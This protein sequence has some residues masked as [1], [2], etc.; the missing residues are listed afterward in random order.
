VENA[1]LFASARAKERLDHEIK[2]ASE[3]QQKLLPKSLPNSPDI[4]VSGFTLACYSVGGDCFDVIELGDGR[5]GF[6]VGDV[7]GKGITAALLATLLQGVFFTT[8]SLDMPLA[9]IF[10]RVNRYLSEHSA[11]E[12]YATVFYGVLEKDGRFEYV[13]AGHVPPLLRRG[14]GDVE[15]LSS[16]NLPVGLFAEAEY[17]TST[18]TMEPGDFLVIY[19]D[20]VSEAANLKREFFEESR[21]RQVLSEFRGD[22]VNELAAA[23]RDAVKAFTQGAP[24]SDDITA[25]VL[26]YKKIAGP[27]PQTSPGEGS[28]PL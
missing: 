16:G 15:D 3:I 10:S 4:A 26:R 23:V 24:Q 28:A 22:T 17:Q 7:A 18:V 8:A 1:R 2:I 20:G 6:F 9:G 5:F 21:L 12:R 27:D 14:S 25:L 19:S 13:N 11:Q